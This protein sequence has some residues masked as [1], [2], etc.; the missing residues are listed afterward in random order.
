MRETA[1]AT[2]ALAFV[3]QLY[4]DLYAVGCR[5]GVFGLVMLAIW[6]GTCQVISSKL[7]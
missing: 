6:F 2:G 7:A 5:G 4:F 3:A 1:V